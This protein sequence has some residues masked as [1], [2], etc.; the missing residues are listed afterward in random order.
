[1]ALC[2]FP[3]SN[4]GDLSADCMVCRLQQE[5]DAAKADHLTQRSAL[6]EQL[7]QLHLQLATEQQAAQTAAARA[8][9]CSQ[10]ADKEL[11]RLQQQVERLQQD[12]DGAA[13]AN[14]GLQQ[15]LA[16]AAAAASAAAQASSTQQQ[17]AERQ[18][19]D[20][21]L[22]VAQLKSETQQ[23]QQQLQAQHDLSQQ[24]ACAAAKQASVQP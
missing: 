4:F 19:A 16:T 1:M 21:L 17:G 14:A 20:T 9:E 3:Y 23:L 11:A 6:V 15:Q 7:Q 12:L 18:L 10:H 2:I 22:Q 13:A 8:S 24:A 5:L